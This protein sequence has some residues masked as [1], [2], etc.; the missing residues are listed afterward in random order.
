MFELPASRRRPATW[1]SA[2]ARSRRS[3]SSSGWRRSPRNV[4]V[5]ADRPVLDMSS[6]KIGVNV[7]PEEVREPAGERPQLRQPDDAG[8]RRHERRQ[9]RLGEGPVQRQVEP[10]E[11]PELRRRGRHLRVGREPGLPERHRLAVPPADVDGVGRGVPRQLGPGAGG[12]RARRGGN[13]TVISK[14]GSNAFR[15]SLFDYI[16]NDAMDSAT[17]YIGADGKRERS[18][19]SIEPVRRIGRRPAQ[20]RTRRSS[21]SASKACVRPPA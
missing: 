4:M 17:K 6:A 11:L 9:R 21:S 3:K 10:A 7:S 19:R 15:G 14:S 12:K 1:C 20:D 16:R 2:S 18:R 8:D 5:S 13:I